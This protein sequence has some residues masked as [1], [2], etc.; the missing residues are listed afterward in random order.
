MKKWE[1]KKMKINKNVKNIIIKIEKVWGY[2]G[3]KQKS[4]SFLNIYTRKCILLVFWSGVAAFQASWY[5]I[6][7]ALW[8]KKVSNMFICINLLY[9]SHMYLKGLT[10]RKEVGPP[11]LFSLFL[12]YIYLLFVIFLCVLIR[13]K[14]F[15]LKW[16]FI[17]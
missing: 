2:N 12:I 15:F 16:I 6:L 4:Q 9:T 5:F 17:L 7:L 3:E 1:W 10:R 11:T 14:Y 8:A 13:V